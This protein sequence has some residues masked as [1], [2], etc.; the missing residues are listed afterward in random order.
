MLW[1]DW[2]WDLKMLLLI[3]VWS[4]LSLFFFIHFAILICNTF[5]PF[6]F[7]FFYL[8]FI[9]SKT[10]KSSHII[11][12]FIVIIIIIYIV[13]II[14]IIIYNSIITIVLLIIVITNLIFSAGPVTGMA[15]VWDY[16]SG[17]ALLRN[18]NLRVHKFTFQVINNI[19]KNTFLAQIF[20]L[21]VWFVCCLV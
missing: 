5:L 2:C 4:R 17:S 12:I 18:F 6:L 14:L 8:Q 1:F 19:Q 11:I 7:L 10:F 13:I 3:V 21:N 9:D 16:L 20:L 15:R